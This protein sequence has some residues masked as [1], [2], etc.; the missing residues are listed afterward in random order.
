MKTVQA[1]LLFISAALMSCN[2]SQT[3]D[4]DPREAFIDSLM[5]EMTLDEKLGQL[6]LPS[7]GDITTGEATNSNVAEDIRA[8]KV[9]GLFNIATAEKIRNVQRIA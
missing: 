6:N 5:S 4:S 2:T 1:L 7:S 8:G 3:S 9:G